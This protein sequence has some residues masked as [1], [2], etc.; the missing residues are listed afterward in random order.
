MGKTINIQG[1][2]LNNPR[3]KYCYH[4]EFLDESR[5]MLISEK[6]S[7]IL[8]GKLFCLILLELQ[9]Q[10]F[11]LDGLTKALQGKASVFEI[12]YALETLENRGYL[13][14][15]AIN[16]SPESCAYWESQGMQAHRLEKVLQEKSISLRTLGSI[17]S[18]PFID[19]FTAAGVRTGDQGV[20]NVLITDDYER[21]ELRQINQ[22]ALQQKQ[23]WLLIKPLGVDLW[24]GP[25]FQPE[26]GACWQCLEQR[27]GINRPLNTFYK[28]QNN[29][30]ENLPIP[31]AFSPL[32]LQIAA[33]Q[34]VQEVIKWLYWGKNE[35]LESKIVTYNTQSLTNKIHNL[36]KRPQCKACGD[37]AFKQQLPQPIQL[38]RGTSRCNAALGGYREAL[39]EE[40]LKR[41]GHHVSPIT[42]VVQLL[43]PYFKS[44]GAPIF[45]YLSGRNLAL[46]SK[47]LFWLN[48]HVRSGNGGKGR[49]WEQAK[50]GALCEAIERY[51]ATY[52]E[53]DQAPVNGSLRELEVE[54]IHPNSCMN[55]SEKQYRER[56]AANQD[57]TKF[58]SLVPIP[59][60]ETIQM[61]WHPVYSLTQQK[62][63]YLPSCFCFAQYPAEDE[64]RLFAYPDS[65]GCAAGNSM[66]EAILQG[67]LELVERDSVALWWYNR[68]QTL[69]VDLKSFQ[70]PYFD[71]LMEYYGSLNRGLYVLDITTDLQIPSFIAISYSMEGEKQEIV[72]GCGTHVEASIGIERALTELNQILPIANVSPED[73]KQGK[74]RTQD[75]VFLQWLNTATLENQPYLKPAS[76]QKAKTA[77]D[78]PQL[79][80]PTVYDALQFCLKSTEAQGLETLVL[81]LTRAD[82]GL[83]VVKVILPGLRHFWAR[84]APGR[85]Y[86]IPVK[87]G[88]FDRPLKEE[89]LNPIAFF[90]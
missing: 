55:Y 63:K 51:S 21:E 4:A 25:L 79:C 46:R 84:F 58:Y 13:T 64:L 59:F 52:H 38:K 14:E 24:I 29:T 39:P 41:F 23:P 82:V 62:F 8:T 30:T 81:D 49:N 88:W 68:H 90:L 42:G 2:M 76:Q 37:Q 85:L 36:I 53:E 19:A 31:P 17:S 20:L 57:C 69:G 70:D 3:I 80:A 73:R 67:L 89:E 34:T 75:D 78:Y 1:I 66:E 60:D 5:V 26:E 10:A 9:K 50:V 32:S 61:D 7:T 71:Q 35:Q 6:D 87:L 18:Q 28:S 27:L 47:S 83:N 72:F 15:A 74:Y 40:T 16:L 48:N 54:V 43:E 86:E 11:S 65:N 44:E 12:Y 77:A 56:E 45:N 22:E 33:N